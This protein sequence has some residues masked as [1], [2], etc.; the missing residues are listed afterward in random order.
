MRHQ[1]FKIHDS[2]VI[3]NKSARSSDICRL[4]VFTVGL[5]NFEPSYALWKY[6]NCK[7]V[8]RVMYLFSA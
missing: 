8:I 7:I 2:D 6:V 1:I 4:G 3:L 5:C